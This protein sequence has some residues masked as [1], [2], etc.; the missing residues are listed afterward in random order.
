MGA[1]LESDAYIRMD[2]NHSPV[3]YHQALADTDI[4]IELIQQAKV[5]YEKYSLNPLYTTASHINSILIKVFA[6]LF[7]F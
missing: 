2:E 6:K 1:W 7:Y 3:D 4:Y 5:F